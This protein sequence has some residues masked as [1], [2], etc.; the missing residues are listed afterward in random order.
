MLSELIR[1]TAD[2]VI[3]GAAAGAAAGTD[4]ARSVRLPRH[5]GQW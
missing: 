2:A 4:A 1:T 3:S 5:A